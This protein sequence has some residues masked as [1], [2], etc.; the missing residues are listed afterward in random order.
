MGN[1][2]CNFTRQG[3]GLLGVFVIF[4][5]PM[6][7]SGRASNVQCPAT[8]S[9]ALFMNGSVAC[10]ARCLASSAFCRQVF[11]SDD[12]RGGSSNAPNQAASV[13]LVMRAFVHQIA[14]VTFP[15]PLAHIA[16]WRPHSPLR[17]C[18]DQVATKYAPEMDPGA[19][20]V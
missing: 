12:I 20:Q 8:F 10:A 19:A 13:A 1:G 17:P 14:A 3:P 15:Q 4:S 7:D 18:R 2:D 6:R 11:L 9:Y 16:I 5:L